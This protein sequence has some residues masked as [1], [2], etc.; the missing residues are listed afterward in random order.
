MA[1]VSLWGLLSSGLDGLRSRRM[2]LPADARVSLG[3]VAVLAALIVLTFLPLIAGYNFLPFAKYPN[4]GWADAR[5]NGVPLDVDGAFI[6]RKRAIPWVSDMDF[7]HLSG[8]FPGDFYTAERL[9]GGA[10]PLWDP[11]AGCGYPTF[12]SGQYRPFNLLRWPFYVFPTYWTYCLTL[13]LGIPLGAW[14][15]LLWL[16]REGYRLPEATLGAALFAVNPWVLDRLTIQ[17]PSAFFLLPWVLLALHRVRW[18]DLRSMAL[19]AL[20]IVVMGNVGQPEPCLVATLVASAHFLVKGDLGRQGH[21]SWLR[22]LW[23]LALI[24]LLSSLALSIHWVP[25]IRLYAYA[26][27]YKKLSVSVVV[28]YSWQGLFALASD[29]FIAPAILALVGAALAS[30]KGHIGFWV[31]ALTLVLFL[32]MPLPWAGYTIQAFLQTHLF[33]VPLV[34]FKGLLWTCLAFIAPAG[35]S[36]LLW[37]N[38]R[39]YLIAGSV[40]ALALAGDAILLHFLPLPLP[41]QSRF[42]V[43]AMVFLALGLGTLLAATRLKS[44]AAGALLVALVVTLPSAFPLSLNH[45]AWNTMTFQK[46]GLMAWI[47]REHPHDRTVSPVSRGFVIPPNQGSA[48]GVRCAILTPSSSWDNT[49]NY[50]SPRLLLPHSSLSETRPLC[51]YARAGRHWR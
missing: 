21:H 49:S 33:A 22:R 18:G 10:L 30:R 43:L 13:A 44:G 1:R 48:Y 23:V 31:S 25:L 50:F 38:K 35:L 40:G 41:E 51:C 47:R 24:G 4:W 37:G 45:L 29:I 2:A 36:T 8:F 20:A 32:I 39:A 17:D 19:A 12:D 7:G 6:A 34:Y 42:P 9:R 3:A 11:Y 14:G 15:A 28:P 16:K 5:N 27:S 46:G 26:F